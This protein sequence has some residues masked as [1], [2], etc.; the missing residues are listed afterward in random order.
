MEKEKK[1]RGEVV[2]KILMTTVMEVA[3]ENGE[4]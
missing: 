1:S 2:V 3:V 4:N